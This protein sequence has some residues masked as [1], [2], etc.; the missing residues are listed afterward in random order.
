MITLAHLHIRSA[1]VDDAPDFHRLYDFRRPR[2]S[3]LDKAREP[4]MPTRDELALMLTK[5]ENLKGG[6]Y[7]LDDI[8]GNVRGFCS[9][10]GMVHDARYAE[11]SI[12]FFDD[13]DYTSPLAEEALDFICDEAFGRFRLFKLIT[14][15]L[16]NETAWT[17]FVLAHGF[18]QSGEQRQ[19]LFAGGKW[20]NLLTFSR[21][22]P[23]SEKVF[24]LGA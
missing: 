5:K 23:E 18:E 19:V 21:F 6:L 17:Q 20:H 2:A 16:G 13:S 3:L 7:V 14:Q 12:L 24:S 11:M 22:H 10:R 9:L 4:M 1:D 8:E 15:S